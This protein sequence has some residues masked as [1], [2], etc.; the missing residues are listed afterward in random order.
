LQLKNEFVVNTPIG[1]AWLM[2]LNVERIARCV[3]GGEL[4]D[5]MDERTF[6]G[7][8]SVKLGPMSLAF[9]GIAKFVDVQDAVRRARIEAQGSDKKGRGAAQAKVTVQLQPRDAVTVVNIATD[10]QLSGAVAQ[11]GRASGLIEAVSRQIVEEFADN[12]NRQ[13]TIA[14]AVA[15]DAATGP[16]VNASIGSTS[17]AGFG[18][19]TRMFR[20]MFGRWL[21]KL[22]HKPDAK[23]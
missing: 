3:P 11:I 1:A 14:G 16:E 10:L 7:R 17:I 18:F 13:I 22:T 20:A 9:E 15:A 6:K 2:L 5:K 12:L 21:A 8:V 23:P 4:L 19:A